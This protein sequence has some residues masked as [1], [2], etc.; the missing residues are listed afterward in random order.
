MAERTKEGFWYSKYE[1]DLPTPVA[2]DEP[3]EGQ[4]G[5]ITRLQEVEKVAQCISYRGFSS[6]RICGCMNGSREFL[7]NGFRWPQGL[8]HYITEHNV[9]PSA[10]FREMINESATNGLRIVK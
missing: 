5:F 2:N 3:W 1:P 10:E 7:H 6:C 9:Q 8:M 4:A